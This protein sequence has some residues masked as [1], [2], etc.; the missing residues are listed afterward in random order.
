[1]EGDASSLKMEPG[2]GEQTGG[3]RAHSGTR[4]APRGPRK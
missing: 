2:Q 3:E 1:M 4:S